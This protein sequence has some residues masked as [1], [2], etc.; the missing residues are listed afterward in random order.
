MIKDVNTIIANK[1]SA[2][3]DCIPCIQLKGVGRVLAE[4]LARCG[5]HTIQ[6]LLFHLPLRYQDRTRI[7]PIANLLLGD[8]ALVTGT[9]VDTLIKPRPRPN[10]TCYL[11]DQTG[12][13]MIRFF[14][15]NS[16]QKANLIPGKRLTVFGEV[17]GF[18]HNLSMIHPEYRQVQENIAPS[19]L[20]H[21]TPVYPTTAGLSQHTLNILID[22]ALNLLNQG[23]LLHEYLPNVLLT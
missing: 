13:L 18:G 1:S 4:T 19:A 10:L 11:Q 16:Q 20:P 17:R 9:I 12:L 23:H 3:L 14:H 8:T 6:D 2:P 21:L 15:F 22:Q 5:I 7:T